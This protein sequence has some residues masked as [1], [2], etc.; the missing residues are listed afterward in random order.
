MTIQAIQL[1]NFDYRVFYEPLN[2]ELRIRELTPRDFYISDEFE[3]G[4]FE[5]YF[6][7]LEKCCNQPIGDLPY[8]HLRSILHWFIKTLYVDFDLDSWYKSAYAL[9]RGRWGGDLDW[10]E[11]Q[12]LSKIQK[13]LEILN[14]YGDRFL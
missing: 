4:T 10:L 8:L 2:L 1:E 3:R 11:K 5:Y 7:L 13:M 12:P 14:Q 9:L 6:H